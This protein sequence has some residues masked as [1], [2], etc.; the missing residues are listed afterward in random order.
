MMRSSRDGCWWRQGGWQFRVVRKS[1][2]SNVVEIPL[3]SMWKTI[4]ARSFGRHHVAVGG[5]LYGERSIGVIL[6]GMGA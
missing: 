5:G 6:T 4:R 3:S 2:T 1:I